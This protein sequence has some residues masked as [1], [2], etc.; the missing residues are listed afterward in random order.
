MKKDNKP[1]R[2]Y[3]RTDELGMIVT[4]IIKGYHTETD[5]KLNKKNLRNKRT[6][7]IVAIENSVRNIKLNSIRKNR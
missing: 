1:F 3:R 2:N 4:R 6:Q 5:Q 7:T